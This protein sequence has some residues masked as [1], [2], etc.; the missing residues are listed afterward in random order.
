MKLKTAIAFDDNDLW[1]ELY[2]RIFD[3]NQISIKTYSSPK[4]YFC[5]KED[6]DLC[7]VDSPCT[8]F[9]ITD[10]NMPEMT[11]LEF[12]RK[13]K[14]M[15]CKIPDNCKAIISGTWTEEEFEEAKKLCCNVLDAIGK[16][17]PEPFFV[18]EFLDQVDVLDIAEP[19]KITSICHE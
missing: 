11:G 3:K 12:M 18:T 5:Q 9:L 14:K 6:F 15:R 8:D 17:F 16:A 13:A 4:H 1:C 2:K 19:G 10:H 7:P